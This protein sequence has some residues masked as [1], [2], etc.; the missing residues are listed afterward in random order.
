MISETQSKLRKLRGRGDENSQVHRP[1][2]LKRQQQGRCSIPPPVCSLLPVESHLHRRLLVVLR[3]WNPKSLP[4]LC[5]P[6]RLGGISIRLKSSNEVTNLLS[7]RGPVVAKSDPTSGL[8]CSSWAAGSQITKQRVGQSGI[9]TD[10]N[11]AAEHCT[12]LVQ[13][14]CHF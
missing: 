11:C 8:S 10:V 13:Q 9:G 7:R 5:L 6:P 3:N 1:S 4:L 2:I 14:C 12:E